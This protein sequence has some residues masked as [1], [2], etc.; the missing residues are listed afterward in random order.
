MSL[1]SPAFDAEASLSLIATTSP[2][3]QAA[4]SLSDTPKA[5]AQEVAILAHNQ[6]EPAGQQIAIAQ[7]RHLGRNRSGL[8]SSWQGH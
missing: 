1:L 5:Q 8:F 3:E 6:I 2:A 4:I 7:N